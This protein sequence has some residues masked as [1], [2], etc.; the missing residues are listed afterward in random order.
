MLSAGHILSP[1]FGGYFLETSGNDGNLMG[2]C[3][4]L[5]TLILLFID[6]LVFGFVLDYWGINIEK[7]TESNFLET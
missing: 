7:V 4:S 1:Q 3:M 2:R 5:K 6:N